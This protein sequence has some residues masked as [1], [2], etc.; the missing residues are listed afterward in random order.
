MSRKQMSLLSDK[1]PDDRI[2]QLM[3]ILHEAKK[4]RVEYVNPIDISLSTGLDPYSTRVL[5]VQNNQEKA[6]EYIREYLQCRNR[7]A[8]RIQKLDY[9]QQIYFENF[10]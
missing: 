5:S 9:D 10:A 2:L 6:F 8:R 1:Y 7:L 4:H 3:Y